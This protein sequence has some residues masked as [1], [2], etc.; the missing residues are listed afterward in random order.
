MGFLTYWGEPVKCADGHKEGQLSITWRQITPRM[1]ENWSNA[2]HLSN[3]WLALVEDFKGF[4]VLTK[5]AWHGKLLRMTSKLETQFDASSR[6]TYVPYLFLKVWTD[7]KYRCWNQCPKV[8]FFRI[9][10]FTKMQLKFYLA[11]LRTEVTSAR[12]N[13]FPIWINQQ[14]GITNWTVWWVS[15]ASGGISG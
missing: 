13:G 7:L 5:G 6:A 8:T 14:K 10:I 4:F 9:M 12:L 2:S 3:F 15:E 1:L 11:T